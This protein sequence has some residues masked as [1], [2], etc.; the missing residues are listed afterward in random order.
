MEK[1][2]AKQRITTCM[3]NVCKELCVTTRRLH[4]LTREDDGVGMGHG[5]YERTY[6]CTST[7]IRHI[8]WKPLVDT[9]KA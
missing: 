9:M 4:G 5:G 3:V 8:K 6:A 2:V 7:Q 1:S